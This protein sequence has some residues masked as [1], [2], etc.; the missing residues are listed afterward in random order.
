MEKINPETPDL[1]QE[2]IDK[3][4]ELFPDVV[5]E[6]LG[7][8]GNVVRA[9][10]F[11]AL[12]GDLFGEVVEGKKERYQF[13]WPGKAAAKLEA[14]TPCDKTMRPCPEESV[15][16]DT[17]Q[18]L[19]IEGDN[20]EALKIMRE[21]Y[22]GMVKL[23]YIDPP[24]NT[25]HD[26]IYD[27]D[28]SQSRDNYEEASDEF[29]EEGGRL[30]ANPESNGRFHSDWCSM[31]YPRLMIARDMLSSDGII[32]INIGE[33]E[34]DNTSKMCNEVFNSSNRITIFVRAMKTGGAKGRFYTPSVDYLLVYAKDITAAK[35]F[36][37]NFTQEQID[38][39]YKYTEGEGSRTGE[40]YGIER[41]YKASLDARPNQ[42][43]YIKCPDGS[44]VI[45][46]GEAM[47][48]RLEEGLTVLPGVGDKVWKW[49]YPRF[50]KELEQNRIVFKETG[51]S[52]LV[53]SNGKPSRWNIYN[54]MYL[55]EQ[56]KKGGVVPS[57]LMLRFENRQSAKE[58]KEL[59]IPFDYA[60]PVG[61]I[62][63]VC[64][65]VGVSKG[66]VVL[67]FFSGSAS[68][69]HA[70]MLNASEAHYIMIQLPEKCDEGSDA[71]KKG[72]FTICDIGKERIRR[73]GTRIARDIEQS[74]RQLRIGEDLKP[75]PDIGFRVLKVDSSNYQNTYDVPAAVAQDSL[76]VF[77]DNLKTDRTSEDLLFQVMPKFRIPYSA[78]IDKINLD[79]KEVFDVNNGQLLVCF[80]ANVGVDTIEEIAKRK[81]VYAV[82]RDASLVD[83]ST[84]ANFEELFKT[85]S[86]DTIRRVI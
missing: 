51:T 84:A 23:I 3:I 57:N 63:Y 61:L 36:R 18:N 50:K 16:W 48:S 19:Y 26:F 85:F 6:T 72:F 7:E 39:F 34:V 80:D 49:I 10:D 64:S 52:S 81:P 54:K 74:N 1:T 62:D 70:V 31:M 83:D 15:N 14:R 33:D 73:A 21:T 27:D 35:A 86:P 42:R 4:A 76:D 60:K 65:M 67:D 8:D 68:T 12:K 47:P 5:T 38:I 28:F 71:K 69:A 2:N 55:K 75:V 22:A 77:I 53:D 41:L 66:D 29:D 25:G 32:I 78:T 44:F 82:L 13:T 59:D 20:L 37:A 45:P 30:V 11:D 58:L 79:G 9:I 40:L 56:E 17:T 46:P 43:Y 24:Y